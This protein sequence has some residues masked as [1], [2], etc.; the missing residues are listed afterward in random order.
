MT[1]TANNDVASDSLEVPGWIYIIQ[2]SSGGPFKLGW[3]LD[4][5]MRLATLQ[6]G[7]PA[8][9]ELLGQFQGTGRRERELHEMLKE[10]RGLGEW[11][12]PH[13]RAKE[14]LAEA[15]EKKS[16]ARRLKIGRSN[17]AVICDGCHAMVHAA[18]PTGA[19]WLIRPTVVKLLQ[20]IE[21]SEEEFALSLLQMLELDHAYWDSFRDVIKELDSSVL[22]SLDFLKDDEHVATI[23][24]LFNEAK[25][26]IDARRK[27]D[28]ERERRTERINNRYSELLG[29]AA[30]PP[31][32]RSSPAP[33]SVAAN[34]K[35]PSASG[36]Q[37]GARHICRKCGKVIFGDSFYAHRN[38]CESG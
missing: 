31:N 2:A 7:N 16:I 14:I 5:K 10:F 28:E 38:R 6:I 36:G 21:R 13:P 32:A 9:L 1:E 15:S 3:A 35:D 26:R 27:L 20:K 29:P 18:C 25:G 33:L 34:A 17:T 12:N 30:A 23:D 37:A 8:R 24:R 11:F 19:Y 4:P 22:E